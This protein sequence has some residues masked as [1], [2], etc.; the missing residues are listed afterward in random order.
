MTVLS[1]AGPAKEPPGV[2]NPASQ[3]GGATAAGTSKPPGGTGT[4]ASVE[5]IEQTLSE[6][7]DFYATRP[8]S[9]STGSSVL[10]SAKFMKMCLDADL[11]DDMQ[12]TQASDPHARSK[13]LTS[14]RVDLI[15]KKLCGNRTTMTFEQFMNA[16][17]QI[18]LTKYPH[19][20]KAYEALSILYEE[21]FSKFLNP[22][23]ELLGVFLGGQQDHAGIGEES[24]FEA[25][26]PVKEAVL[27]L[28]Q[29]Y[30]CQE[31][32][33]HFQQQ[34]ASLESQSMKAFLACLHDF[35]IA[36][37]LVPKPICLSVFREVLKAKIPEEFF[38]QFLKTSELTEEELQS[39]PILTPEELSLKGRLFTI[40]HFV[41][42]LYLVG[43][44]LRNDPAGLL[45]QP[46]PAVVITELL[47]RMDVSTPGKIIFTAERARSLPLSSAFN[48]PGKV[49]FSFFPEPRPQSTSSHST[50]Q[51]GAPASSSSSSQQNYKKPT[52]QH[53]QQIG[54]SS[55]SSSSATRPR[56]GSTRSPTTGIMKNGL[57]NNFANRIN[58]SGSSAGRRNFS[59]FLIPDDVGV[60]LQQQLK[61]K[62][63]DDG[64]VLSGEEIDH[65]L[66][67][68]FLYY[69]SL[70]DPLNRNSMSSMKFN[71]FLRDAGLLP[72]EL[73]KGALS[74]DQ[75]SLQV[76]SKLYSNYA[77]LHDAGDYHGSGKCTRTAN[78]ER[79][80]ENS[81]FVLNQVD[82]DL[83]FLQATNYER[84][85]QH[86]SGHQVRHLLTVKSWRRAVA[87]IA[88]RRYLELFGVGVERL[89]QEQPEAVI[90]ATA[91]TS[92]AE[93]ILQPLCN[94]LDF[95]SHV[96]VS[97]F[98]V[99]MGRK[100]MVE[101]FHSP[102]ISDGISKIFAYYADQTYTTSAAN[103][104]SA[105]MNLNS[106]R[107]TVNSFLK[108]CADFEIQEE[109]SHLPLQR[110]FQDCAQVEL[111][112]KRTANTLP[113]SKAEKAS[114]D[115]LT[116]LGF[117]L[118]LVLLAVKLNKADS[119]L[120]SLQ[121]QVIALL[122]KLNHAQGGMKDRPSVASLTRKGM[123]FT[124]LPPLGTLQL[125]NF[126]R[127]FDSTSV[128]N[129]NWNSVKSEEMFLRNSFNT[130][131]G[132]T[133]S[134]SMGGGGS[135]AP[136][137]LTERFFRT[138]RT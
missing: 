126:R 47:E 24:F 96:D 136:K 73:P 100:E 129:V 63:D 48:A 123:L 59:K 35:E 43:K 130:V 95:Q 105:M 135:T 38:A 19:V 113:T 107:W 81:D 93:A 20:S 39:K 32:N 116:R 64:S 28:Y 97:N 33:P 37:N 49:P 115:Q 134:S 118:S 8:H 71:R 72:A 70:G 7:F 65:L 45:Q 26:A 66:Q 23:A 6:I 82:V 25:I 109:L 117:Q 62:E 55:S 51:T 84:K 67:Q 98:A 14:A 18:A 125:D 138:L 16:C 103:A 128:E 46:S 91:I 9:K 17:V 99:E 2:M 21:H 1:A 83:I 11:V 88:V 133:S 122:H 53:L 78:L 60:F 3:G 119:S 54:G 56:A 42:G 108:F 124:N 104:N 127:S 30:F 102:N 58:N 132:T 85:K 10:K 22:H 101:L 86:S 41:I 89:M 74:F 131:A 79:L 114:G 57:S 75:K 106:L 94:A 40:G 110:I 80:V 13:L 15:F 90:F 68:L 92:F 36:P 44:K 121:D 137:L 61:L 29:G 120:P 111:V 27:T 5:E 69:S 31:L 4:G 52:S 12:S 77:Q 112:E 76:K 34:T 87:D 50:G